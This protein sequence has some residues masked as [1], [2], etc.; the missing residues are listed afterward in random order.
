MRMTLGTCKLGKRVSDER[1]GEVTDVLV[2]S[3]RV[4]NGSQNAQKNWLAKS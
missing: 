2:F 4:G 3:L 1:L